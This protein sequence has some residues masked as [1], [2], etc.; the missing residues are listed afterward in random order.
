MYTCMVQQC[1][2][3]FYTFGLL[4]S[5]AHHAQSHVS[6]GSGECAETTVTTV[7]LMLYMLENCLPHYENKAPKANHP[8]FAL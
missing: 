5:Q 3:K 2:T 1:H 4:E 8:T 6:H 7:L